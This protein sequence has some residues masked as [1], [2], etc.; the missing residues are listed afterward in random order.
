[1]AKS[2]RGHDYKQRAKAASSPIARKSFGQGPGREAALT[3]FHES[4][5]ALL[6]KRRLNDIFTLVVSCEDADLPEAFPFDLLVKILDMRMTTQQ[7]HAV[8]DALLSQVHR[9][10]TVLKTTAPQRSETL[11]MVEVARV[12]PGNLFAMAVLDVFVPPGAAGRPARGAF[13][14]A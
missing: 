5:R 2:G 6:Q 14:H 1:M 8:D 10:A 13:A 12:L 4:L 11:Q 3:E 7:P 9:L